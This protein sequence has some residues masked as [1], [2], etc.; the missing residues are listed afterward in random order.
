MR[1]K[2]EELRKNLKKGFSCHETIPAHVAK[3][4]LDNADIERIE[5]LPI[6]EINQWLFV[7]FEGEDWENPV[8]YFQE[9]T[10]KRKV[11]QKYHTRE[12]NAS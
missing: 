3:Y 4:I 7:D 2:F 6:E 10:F 5:Q 12:K 9:R 1:I 8:N 11:L